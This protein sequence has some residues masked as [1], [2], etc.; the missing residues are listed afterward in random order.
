MSG[1]EE[2]FYEAVGGHETFAL[3]VERF[4]AGV[5]E[6]PLLAPMY[7]DADWDGARWRLEHFLAQYWGGPTTYS[8][9]RGHP[10]LRLRH[11]PFQ[12]T[13]TAR[14]RWLAHMRAS[15]LSL[16]LSPLHEATLWDYL[17]RAAHAMVNA[18]EPGTEPGTEADPL[19]P[20]P[21]RSLL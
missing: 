8:Q 3:L 5:R 12:V 1:A 6:D 7:P 18:A 10:R 4:Y 11:Q 15:L 21:G 2:S 16:G 14:D 13:P 20:P 17:E 9:E 19:T